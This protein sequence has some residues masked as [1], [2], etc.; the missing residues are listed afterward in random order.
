MQ[1]PFRDVPEDAY[2]YDAVVWGLSRGV[3]IGPTM[4][5][6]SLTENRL[7]IV[8]GITFDNTQ[9]DAK[10]LAKRN[11]G[12]VRLMLAAE[13]MRVADI[14]VL[15]SWRKATRFVIP[16]SEATWESRAGSCVF[17]GAILLSGRVLRDCHGPFG[18]SQ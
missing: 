15:I 6:F 10:Y 7:A 3:V 18:S 13:M 5:T 16:R 17:A 11:G 8:A 1:L 2:Y 14:E 12:D 9:E 4:T